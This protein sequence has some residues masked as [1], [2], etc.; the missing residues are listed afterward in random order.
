MRFLII[1]VSLLSF[2]SAF[3]ALKC[4]EP[5]MMQRIILGSAK[6]LSANLINKE[7]IKKAIDG[8]DN[9]ERYPIMAESI[10]VRA[11][12]PDEPWKLTSKEYTS[13]N[14]LSCSYFSKD[15]VNPV[16]TFS[17]PLTRQ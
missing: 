12:F 1:L 3:A 4:P 7:A 5:V 15:P 17:M 9:T 2:S 8:G 10:K 16:L 11:L 6:E 14:K 13:A